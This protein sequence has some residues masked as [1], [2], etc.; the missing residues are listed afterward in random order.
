MSQTDE[1][2][3]ASLALP[4]V[5]KI[6]WDPMHSYIESSGSRTGLD[7]GGASNPSCI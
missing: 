4:G 7:S 1:S 3:S 5:L 6:K 2:I